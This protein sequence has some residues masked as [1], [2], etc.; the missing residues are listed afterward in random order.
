MIRFEVINKLT[1]EKKKKEDDQ[2]RS[3]QT[4]DKV[5]V[6]PGEDNQMRGLKNN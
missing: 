4:F 1:D 2:M 5:R 6:H 3:F